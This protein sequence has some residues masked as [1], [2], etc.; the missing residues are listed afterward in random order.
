M[1]GQSDAADDLIA[2]L[3]KLMAQDDAK[4]SRPGEVLTPTFAVRIPGG[5]NNAP[6]AAPVPRFD[7]DRTT[8]LA[9]EKPTAPVP[10]PS[11]P[12][13]GPATTAGGPEPFNFDFD[14]GSL[15]R[16]PAVPAQVS[17][18]AEPVEPAMAAESTVDHDSIADLIAA[19]LSVQPERVS[20]PVV[21]A[22]A[23]VPTPPPSTAT[24]AASQPASTWTPTAVAANL[25]SQEQ[26]A[27]PALRPLNLQPAPKTEQDRFKVPPVFGLGTKPAGDNG[28]PA[29]AEPATPVAEVVAPVPAEPVPVLRQSTPSVEAPVAQRSQDSEF[30]RDPI[31]EI[32]DLIGRAMRVE[33]DKPS[34]TPAP[35]VAERPAPSPAL[36]TLATPV[37]P[38]IQPAATAA[39]P[40]GSAPRTLS[41]A[42]E[43]ILAAAQATGAEIGWVEA[44]EVDRAEPVGSAAS[45][46]PRRA[47]GVSRAVA[48]PL[49][50]VTLLLAAGFGLYWA[51]GL[52]RESGP[53]PLLTADTSPTKET[54]AVQPDAA[55][56]QQSVVFNEIDGVVPGAEEQL[57]SRDQAD[58]NEVTQVPPA[59]DLSE[60]GL[61]NR[62]VRT[63]TV[64]PDGTIVS[65]DDGVAG[66]AILPVDR[67]LVPEVP[68]AETAS[69]ELLASAAPETPRP[70]APAADAAA[71]PEATPAP[72]T[73][74]ASAVTPVVPGSTV[75]AVD[76][77]GNVLAGKTAP[78]PMQRPAGL[79]QTAAPSP[80]A[81]AVETPATSGNLLPP[82]PAASTLGALP[83][84]QPA[85]TEVA[86]QPAAEPATAAIPGAVEVEAL[87]NSAPA[88]AQLASLR[89][90]QEARDAAQRLVSR[91]GPLFG[92]AN[93]EVQRVDL[94]ARGIYYRVRVP[95]DSAQAANSICTNVIAAGGDCVLM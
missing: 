29:A 27:R 37:A 50:A 64:R 22:P 10:A 63:V 8:A 15:K 39:Q 92:G 83:T 59:A 65:G 44:P 4:S 36:R 60:E 73:A 18:D 91:F 28:R 41:G 79:V 56:A 78:V 20:E 43:A 82:P 13:A 76:V 88:Y 34:E 5:D 87:P 9:A 31:D 67:P 68:G 42:D 17:A 7:F 74:A 33:F 69:P 85:A 1:A 57:V 3:A 71:T 90:E 30:G 77:A 94:G 53:A 24:R 14:I 80:T 49:V 61:A 54:P 75:P 81:A 47:M 32:E 21:A 38:A 46:R 23:P 93:M 16:E 2:E 70:A 66:S 48:G 58:V 89:T 40:A 12:Q 51:L 26:S 6:A 11:A 95:A 55:A 19:E 45:R 86:T 72:A 84:A 25:G 35:A 52:G 62:K